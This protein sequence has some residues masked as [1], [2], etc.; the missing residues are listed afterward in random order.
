LSLKWFKKENAMARRSHRTIEHRVEEVLRD[1]GI[2]S[3]TVDV[4]RVARFL[5]ATV[6]TV[7]ADSEISGMLYRRNDG[8]VIGINQDHH[9]HRQRFS[10]AHEIGHL[11]L[12]GKDLYLDRGGPSV[13]WR[14]AV[15]GLGSDDDEI[16]A[17]HF[18]ACL[19]MPRG[20]L[21]ADL[22]SGQV[23]ADR[24]SHGD[25]EAIAWLAKRYQVSPQAMTLRLVNLRVIDPKAE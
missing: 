2:R 11:C 16:E 21:L 7:S 25:D 10:I 1:S 3:P 15:S 24:L 19:L 12:H 5:G 18:A 22:R 14:D 9:M 8:A 4:R 6:K 23:R 13:Y 20:F 17:N